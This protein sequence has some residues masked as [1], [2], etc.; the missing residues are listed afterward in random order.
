MIKTILV[1]TGGSD[2]DLVVFVWLMFVFVSFS[3][4]LPL[5]STV[6]TSVVAS[7]AVVA[8]SKT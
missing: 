3:L 8:W 7:W 4:I 2:S 6:I 5:K 1:P